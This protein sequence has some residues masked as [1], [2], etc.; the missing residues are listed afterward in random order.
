[1]TYKSGDI[2]IF[3]DG[4][5]QVTDT[6]AFTDLT[7]NRLNFDSGGNTNKFRG[8]CKDLRVY[9]EALTNAQLIALTQ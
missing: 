7:I 6:T 5:I 2:R 9:N 3:I 1:M 8:K 4:V